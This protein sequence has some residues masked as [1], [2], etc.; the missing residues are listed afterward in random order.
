MPLPLSLEVAPSE[1]TVKSGKDSFIKRA[2]GNHNSPSDK[3]D[4]HSLHTA[5]LVRT[6]STSH[7]IKWA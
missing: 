4:P 1:Q 2:I 7:V 6:T 3:L 5:V